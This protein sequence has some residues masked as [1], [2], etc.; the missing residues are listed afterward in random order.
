V[1]STTRLK[2]ARTWGLPGR[3]A[4]MNLRPWLAA[5]GHMDMVTGCPECSPISVTVIGRATVFCQIMIFPRFWIVQGPYH[6]GQKNCIANYAQSLLI[7]FD[8]E[9]RLTLLW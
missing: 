3:S 4:R 5:A 2:W 8:Q 9:D 1:V 6:S 7:F